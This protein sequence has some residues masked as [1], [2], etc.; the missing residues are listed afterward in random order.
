[1]LIAAGLMSLLL[2]ACG[3]SGNNT[4]PTAPTARNYTQLLATLSKRENGI[5]SA[6]Q[7]GLHTTKVSQLQQTLSTYADQQ[8][9]VASELSSAK[10]PSNA[11]AANSALAKGLNDS[12]AAV[13][14][15]LPRVGKASS[16]KAAVAILGS[17]KA[18]VQ[19]GK[20]IDAA[21]AELKSLGYTPGS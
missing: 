17:D 16:V 18:A 15:V 2:A 6:V 7:S 13:R 12:V 14:S 4:A 3:S 8:E 10:P 21:L 19:A 9:K 20:E 1:M 11:Q 5:Q